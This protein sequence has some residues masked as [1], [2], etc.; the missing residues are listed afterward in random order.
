MAKIPHH[1]WGWLILLLHFIGIVGTLIPATSELVKSLTPINLIVSAI[2]LIWTS[3]VTPQLI[4]Y[5]LFVMGAGFAIEVLGVKT[6]LL[7]GSYAYGPTLGPAVFDVPVVMGINWLLMSVGFGLVSN[8]LFSGYPFR[9]LTSA[10]AMTLLDVLLEPVAIRLDYWQWEADTVPLQN[11]L[12]WFLVSLMFQ[13]V[14]H[15][16]FGKARNPV[17]MHLIMSQIA[18]FLSV[19]IFL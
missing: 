10:G 7:F 4:V 19:Y 17:A 12:M 6:G 15:G 11:Y 9:V 3:S 1:A 16:Q 13:A 5:C 18:Y 14:F 2:I 8:S